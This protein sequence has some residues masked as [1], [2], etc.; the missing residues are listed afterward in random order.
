[1]AEN[2]APIDRPSRLKRLR[3]RAWRRGM[4]EMD[5]ILGGFVDAGTASLTEADMGALEALM[6]R[7]DQQLFLWISGAAPPPP[8]AT[9][10][11]RGIAARI[12]AGFDAG[13]ARNTRQA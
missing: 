3:M 7:Q 12:A 9:A 5:L 10:A 6:D 11:E 13:S 4:K 1:M 2:N 8:D